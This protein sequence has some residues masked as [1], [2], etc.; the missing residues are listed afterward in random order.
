MLL[1]RSHCP[2]RPTSSLHRRLLALLFIQ[3]RSACLLQPRLLDQSRLSD[4]FRC[5]LKHLLQYKFSLVHS[6]IEILPPPPRSSVA[7]TTAPLACA[8]PLAERA[9][10]SQRRDALRA[11]HDVAVTSS[12]SPVRLHD[13]LLADSGFGAQT[14]NSHMQ[15]LTP[16]QQIPV[17]NYSNSAPAPRV[18]TH[19]ANHLPLT[20]GTAPHRA[21]SPLAPL[22]ASSGTMPSTTTSATPPPKMSSAASPTR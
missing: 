17:H 11:L 8:P 2:P 7:V 5:L 1:L 16:R 14:G 15:P 3:L 13:T 18:T 4:R 19:V 9:L 6:G 12:P 22:R 21:L 20:V 10:R